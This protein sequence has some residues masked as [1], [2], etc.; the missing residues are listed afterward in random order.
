MGPTIDMLG[1]L[2]QA[3]SAEPRRVPHEMAPRRAAVAAVLR[4]GEIEPEVLFIHRAE[5]PLDPW[6]GHMAFPGGRVEPQDASEQAAAERETEEEVGLRL[7]EA[8]VRAGRL[9]DL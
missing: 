6:S 5:H 1:A 4:Q 8:A 3:L 9:N 2:R 7:A